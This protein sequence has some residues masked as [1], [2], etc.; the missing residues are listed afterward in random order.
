MIPTSMKKIAYLSFF[1][2]IIFACNP[3]SE[4]QKK[5]ELLNAY[6]S[7]MANLKIKIT[8]L[9]NEL[10]KIDTTQKNQ[11]AGLVSLQTLAPQD[12]NHFI[13]LPGIVESEEHIVIQPGIPGV[14]TSVNVTEGQRVSV[15]Q[16]LAETDNRAIRDNI[17][18]L[19][20]NLNLAKTAFEK[21]ERLWNQ[22][23]GS[24]MQFLQAKTQYESLQKSVSAAN[25]QLD[26]TRMKSPIHGIVDQVNIKTGGYAAPGMDGAFHV[27]NNNNM[28]VVLKVAD[29]Y[30]GKVKTGDPVSVL[31]KDINKNVEG[32]VSFVGKVVNPMTR[33]FIVEVAIPKNGE[34]LRPNMLANASI[35][36]ERLKNVIVVP[37]NLIQ[38]EPEGKK[39]ILVASKSQ[40]KLQVAKKHVKTGNTYGDKVVISEGLNAGDR[41]IRK[42]YQDL[43]DGQLITEQ[44]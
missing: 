23:I 42:G 31:L 15:G 34:D 30:I 37:S 41:I 40:N 20:T 32:K 33:T 11:D 27:V 2:L 24:E 26:M 10:S 16:I 3:K 43:T 7:E 6:K 12:F 21:Q 14:V 8:T 29:S 5:R 17:A 38:T 35:N 44:P 1:I 22:K 19:Q 4:V 9:E 28:K 39:Y 36:D 18:Q 25:S 13:D